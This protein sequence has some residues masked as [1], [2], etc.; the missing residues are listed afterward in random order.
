[1]PKLCYNNG[2]QLDDVPACLNL[3]ELENTLIAKNIIFLKMFK[4]PKSRWSAVKDKVIN[5]PLRDNDILKTLSEIPSLPR[6][7]NESGLFPVKLKRKL[8]Y[9]NAHQES[10]VIPAKMN[11]VLQYLKYSKHPGYKNININITMFLMLRLMMK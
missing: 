5:V 8:Q 6:E 11:E 7:L 2:L 10:Y 1:M 9:K 3:N 4:L